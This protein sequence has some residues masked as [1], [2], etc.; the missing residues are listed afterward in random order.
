M[1]KKF[2][3]VGLV[4]L[5]ALLMVGCAKTF[6]EDDVKDFAHPITENLLIGFNE[7]N[8]ARFSQDFDEVMLK[9][10]PEEKF[11]DLLSEI[12]GKIGD[13]IED[14][15]RFVIAVQKKNYI[16]VI[17][18]AGFAQ[19]TSQV[20]ITISFEKVGDSYKVAGLYFNSPKLSE[21]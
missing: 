8:Y 6:K 10:I 3:A 5:V 16:T 2:V 20:K 1:F 14:S 13:Y 11:G 17:Y 21:K 12:K 9:G 18:N 7:G 15:K 4:L 19:E